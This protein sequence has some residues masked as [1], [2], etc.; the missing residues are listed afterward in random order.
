[1]VGRHKAISKSPFEGG[2]LVVEYLYRLFFFTKLIYYIIIIETAVQCSVVRWYRYNG[3]GCHED[4]NSL[5][6]V[7][8]G[9]YDS[10]FR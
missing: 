5:F 10:T 3:R 7:I 1:M 4:L 2:R 8:V 9:S 6:G